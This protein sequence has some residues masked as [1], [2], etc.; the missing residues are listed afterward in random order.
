[1]PN[2][3]PHDVEAERSLLGAMLISKDV[4]QEVS[5]L[6]YKDDFYLE[7][8]Q[9]IFE[10]MHILQ[11]KGEGVDYT[12][13]S[14]YL[15]NIGKIDK[16]GGVEYLVELGESVPTIAHSRYYMKIVE[17]KSILRRLIQQAT[18]VIERASDEVEDVEDFI[19]VTEKEMLEVVRNRNVGE[20]KH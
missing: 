12:T 19:S 14:T 16:A 11:E 13:L 3:Y 7:Q 10:G 1:M 4:C 6:L 15:K 17:E 18:K 20:F 5:G 2:I 9:I 8:H